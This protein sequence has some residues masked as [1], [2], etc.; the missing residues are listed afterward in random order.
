MSFIKRKNTVV[1]RL[2]RKDSIISKTCLNN[3]RNISYFGALHT[4]IDP[5]EYQRMFYNKFPRR[6]L[7]LS[8]ALSLSLS[9]SLSQA[10]IERKILSLSQ[11]LI[12]RKIHPPFFFLKKYICYI[13]THLVHM[14]CFCNI[15]RHIYL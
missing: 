8:P 6:L 4:R 12:E 14:K 9:L 3:S 1:V 2:M 7:S 13:S 11:V 15:H 10:L 5:K